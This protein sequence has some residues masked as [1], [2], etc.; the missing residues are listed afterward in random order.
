MTEK[1]KSAET[2]FSTKDIISY[3]FAGIADTM[4]YQMFSFYIFNYYIAV[5]QLP[6][7]WVVIGF[8]IWT[9]FNALNDPLLGA[10]SDRTS[11]KYGRRRPFI[12]LGL[13]PLIA[14]IILLWTPFG[15]DL[16]QYI[17]FLI[18]INLFD[19]FYTMYSLN[20]TSLFPEMFQN[21]NQRAKA[22]NYVQI[23]NIIGLLLAAIIPTLFVPTSVEPGSE[24]G[25]I[26]GS[27]IM[28]ALA[29]TFGLIFI[30]WGIHERVEYSKDPLKAPSF[31]DS[32]KFTFK[33]KSFTRYVGT[34]LAVWFVFGL[35]PIINP[36]YV[37]FILGVESGFI[38]SIYL[39]ILF[40]SAIAFMLP[41]S[42]LFSKYGPKKAELMALGAL[43]IT[44][45]PFL[46]MLHPI[47]AIFSY[48]S[49]GI[50]FAAVMM[51]RDIMMSTII[52]ADEIQV[53]IRREAAYYGVNALIIR[54]STIGVYLSIMLVFW[55][56]GWGVIYD[57]SIYTPQTNIGIFLLMY[58][59]PA[60]VLALGLLA[61][62]RF[63]ITKEKYDELQKDLD[64]LHNEKGKV[65]DINK[66]DE[67]L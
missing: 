19:F 23:F 31:K 64:N 58:F 21:L 49:A 20:Q 54:L 47:L 39:A 24:F 5:K 61:L 35:V 44:M 1:N 56:I 2:E 6:V 51:G 3:S 14:L 65:V 55:G 17:Y 18:I 27:I 8:M 11:S 25:Y 28:A 57:P 62:T 67:I 63:P 30:K 13:I 59:I 43:I 53:G 26:L 46:F 29:T 66:Y 37:R 33:N 4:S 22:N 41:W 36:Y 45:I 10:I 52:D 12:V 7:L 40:I 38:S 42:K 50:G 16:A 15:P 9:V 60:I 48:M 34:N 32:V